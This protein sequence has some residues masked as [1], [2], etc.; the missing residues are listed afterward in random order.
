LYGYDTWFLILREEQRLSVFENRV[1]R[2]TFGFIR[3]EVTGEWKRLHKG[4]LYD[5]YY[6]GVIK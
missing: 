1:L 4:E 6:I 2:K 3:V 5:L